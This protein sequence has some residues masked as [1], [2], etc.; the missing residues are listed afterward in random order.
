MLAPIATLVFLVSVWFAV[1]IVADL[2]S[3][4]GRIVAALRG[5]VRPEPVP[6]VIVRSR[7][8]V[9]ARRK[10]MRAQPQWRAAA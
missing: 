7:P 3:R 1:A 5:E 2:Y 8:S 4:K 10:P 9:A 6:A